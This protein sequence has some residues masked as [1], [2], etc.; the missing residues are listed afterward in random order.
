MKGVY[1]CMCVLVFVGHR[2][3]ATFGKLLTFLV[4]LPDSIKNCIKVTA[5]GVKMKSEW[6]IKILFFRE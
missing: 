5:V 6:T 3:C 1:V 2:K 4:Y